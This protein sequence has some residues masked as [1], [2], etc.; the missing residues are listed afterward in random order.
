MRSVINNLTIQFEGILRDIIRLYNGETSKVMGS[1]KEDVVEMLL[2]DLLRTEACRDLY[3]DEDRDLFYYA[4][5]NKGL[6]I[7][8]NVAHGFYLPLDYTSYK[9]ILVFLC[10]LRLVRY[11]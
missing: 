11:T 5:T 9:A 10:V 6:N 3:T 4:F 8:N 1:N 7:R 2:D